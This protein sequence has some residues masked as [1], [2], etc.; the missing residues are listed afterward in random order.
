MWLNAIFS[1]SVFTVNSDVEQYRWSALTTEQHVY[2]TRLVVADPI[3][4]ISIRHRKHRP[5]KIW[6]ARRRCPIRQ[7]QDKIAL[8]MFQ[9]FCVTTISLSNSKKKITTTTTTCK[10]KMVQTRHGGANEWRARRRKNLKSPYQKVP[11]IQ[12]IRTRLKNHLIVCLSV[13]H[14]EYVVCDTEG[15]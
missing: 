15:E 5:W 2:R 13:E 11:A 7:P 1:G 4:S 3:V 10:I 14:R 8:P 6:G 12:G 9:T